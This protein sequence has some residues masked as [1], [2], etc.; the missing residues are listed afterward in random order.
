VSDKNNIKDLGIPDSPPPPCHEKPTFGCASCVERDRSA[1]AF[2][3][4]EAWR[5][6]YKPRDCT[7]H[8]K[9]MFAYAYDL[10]NDGL[11][12]LLSCP[13]NNDGDHF[14]CEDQDYEVKIA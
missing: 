7:R 6:T 13:V 2:K 10:R 11:Y 12:G 4:Y 9:R 8:S 1:R 14:D 3:T 5:K